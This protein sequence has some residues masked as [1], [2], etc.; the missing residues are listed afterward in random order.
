MRTRETA[1]YQHLPVSTRF[2]FTVPASV[3]KRLA[4]YVE[5]HLI[6]QT[7]LT[8]WTCG[9][10]EKHLTTSFRFTAHVNVFEATRKIRGKHVMF[11]QILHRG[12]AG[13]AK[14]QLTVSLCLF[15]QDS[16]L[17]CLPMFLKPR[18]RYVKKHMIFET[19]LTSLT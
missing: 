4:K 13:S 2:K 17:P 10:N 14:K 12:H 1:G 6:F 7:I 18:A 15:P 3:L 16:K 9:G 19:I 11:K 5:K 8:S